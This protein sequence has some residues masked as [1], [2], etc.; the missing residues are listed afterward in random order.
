ME[1]QRSADGTVVG[2]SAQRA[3]SGLLP[4]HRVAMASPCIGRLPAAGTCQADLSEVWTPGADGNLARSLA[5]PPSDHRFR[6]LYPSHSDSRLKLTGFCVSSAFV[7]PILP[8]TSKI[9][10]VLPP[11][12][13]DPQA[14]HRLWTPNRTDRRSDVFPRDTL[15]SAMLPAALP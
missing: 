6:S 3:I 1:P 2:T 15:V 11:R 14:C 4:N 9:R 12:S 10:S 13:H 5:D 7:V 8:C